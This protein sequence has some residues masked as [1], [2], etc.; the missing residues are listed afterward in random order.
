MQQRLKSGRR[1]RTRRLIHEH[2]KISH[3][4]HTGRLLPHEYT[5]Y[6]P[7]AILLIVVG[8]LL[9][10]STVSA[11]PGD[12]PPQAGSIGLT[13]TMPAK[14]PTTGATI[15]SPGEQQHFSASPVTVTGTCPPGTIV[16]LYKSDI[17]AGS[18]P[19]T[20]NGTF[21]M[22]VDLLIGQNN[23]VAKVFD[24]LNQPGPDSKTVTTYYDA[25]PPQTSSLAPIN[26]SASQLILN[27]DAVY[28][29]IF[30]GQTLSIPVSIIG[31]TPPYAINVQWGDSSNKIVPRN[32][33]VTFSV[34][35][36]YNKPGTFQ[37]T[38]QG[39][40]A[41]GRIAFLTVAAIVNGQPGPLVASTT[42][43]KTTPSQLLVLWPL[44]AI[45]ATMVASFWLGERR[46][47]RILASPHLTVHSSA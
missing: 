10:V 33:N 29:G 9:T 14:P 45:A 26:F 23:L 35:H 3:R 30:P 44:F 19:C 37:I 32:N 7:L 41:Q 42:P 6:L 18:T 12:P 36:V 21:S 1:H 43:T 16:E 17:F 28:R 20:D 39:T 34:D 31:G 5:S 47:K 2:M 24:A 27:T 38:L 46:E 4:R 25:L 11:A 13:G 8:L 15:T 40:D 22:T